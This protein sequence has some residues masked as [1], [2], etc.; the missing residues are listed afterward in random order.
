MAETSRIPVS[1]AH[2]RSY[3]P[4]EVRS[5]IRDLLAPLGGMASCVSPGQRVLLKPNLLMGKPPE[6]AVTT[7]PE[8][9]RAVA[10]EIREAGGRVFLGDSPGLGSLESV[11]KRS[12]VAAVA[13][14]MGV[15]VV[16][17]QTPRAISVP[18][19]GVYRSL[20]VAAEALDFDVIINL[21]KLKTH[22]QMTLT[23]AVKNLFGLV[24]GA[25]KP[26]WHLTTGSDLRMADLLLDIYRAIAPDLNIL[27]GVWAMEGNGPGSGHPRPLGLLGASPSALG[28]DR[29]IASLLGVGPDRFSLIHRA[30][31]RGMAEADPDRLEVIGPP[32]GVFPTKGFRLPASIKKVDFTLPAWLSG[33]LRHS[34]ST[35]PVPDRER[36]TSCGTCVEI[37]PVDAVAFGGRGRVSVDEELCINCFCCQEMCPEGAIGLAPGRLLRLLRRMGMA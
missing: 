14:E 34:L 25:A 8:I 2:C 36:C 6:A 31:A 17:F 28:L 13:E 7:H 18:E 32:S 4:A 10:A 1:L 20:E 9:L 19:G 21:P 33:S 24:V 3:D 27:D 35:F 16:P 30:R 37:C 5:S 22:G 11:M 15:G 12:G 26:G 23:L 29:V